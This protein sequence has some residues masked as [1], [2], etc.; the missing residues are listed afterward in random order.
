MW[1]ALKSEKAETREHRN[2]E[3]IDGEIVKR[4]YGEDYRKN[5]KV[6]RNTKKKNECK[7]SENE[8]E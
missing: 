6:K 3:R 7:E 2:W 8:K 5:R 4:K 1:A